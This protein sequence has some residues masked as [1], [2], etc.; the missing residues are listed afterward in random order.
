MATASEFR[1]LKDE[2]IAR[3]VGELRQARFDKKLQHRIGELQNSAELTA[4]RKDLARLLTVQREKQLAA[5][6][7]K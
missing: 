5:A 7:K 4:N 1:E 6:K 2:E 3:R